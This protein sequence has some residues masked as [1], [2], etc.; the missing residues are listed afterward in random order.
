MVLSV[1]VWG[2]GMTEAA[3]YVVEYAANARSKC[4]NK[5]CSEKIEKGCIRIGLF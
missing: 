3:S 5:P 1:V 2:V 4:A